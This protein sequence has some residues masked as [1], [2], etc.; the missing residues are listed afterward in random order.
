MRPGHVDLGPFRLKVAWSG[1][2]LKD[3]G[4]GAE[5]D[6]VG[7]FRTERTEILMDPDQSEESAKETLVHE[8]LH[9]CWSLAALRVGDDEERIVDALAP[10]VLEIVRRNPGT[11]A[12]LLEE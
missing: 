9:A 8:L 11:A 4:R 5:K 3:L 6:L 10:L 2:R 12:W 7:M 1:A